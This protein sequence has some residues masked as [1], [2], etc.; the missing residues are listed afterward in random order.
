M[1]LSDRS[2]R[3]ALAEQ[4]LHICPFNPS[5]VQPS[6]IDV[7]LDRWFRVFTLSVRHWKCPDCGT[8]H[9]RDH[10]AAKNILAAGLAVAGETPGDACGA[11]V[12]LQGSSLQQSATKQELSGAS[13]MGIPRLQAGE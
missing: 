13:R 4:R 12:S 2:L 5:I 8:R 6:S 10:N 3:A 7:R 9:D 11:G 1:L